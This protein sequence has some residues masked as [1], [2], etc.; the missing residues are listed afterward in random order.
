MRKILVTVMVACI[1]LGGCGSAKAE[2]TTT[3]ATAEATTPA[4]AEATAP[5]TAEA[6]APATAETAAP[7]TASG[8]ASVQYEDGEVVE[9][10]WN[11]TM[12]KYQF[13]DGMEYTEDS[14]SWYP[15]ALEILSN[16]FENEVD[17]YDDDEAFYGDEFQVKFGSKIYQSYELPDSTRKWI[18]ISVGDFKFI[19]DVE[20]GAL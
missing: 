9:I 2:Q 15:G 16:P 10:S 7:A 1:L 13:S 3:P 14:E 12:I 20:T 5:A 11:E 19:H 8:S 6:T 4:T 17:F 18:D